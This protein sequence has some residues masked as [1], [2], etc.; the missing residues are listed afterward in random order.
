MTGA[1]SRRDGVRGTTAQPDACAVATRTLGQELSEDVRATLCRSARFSQA[2]R[3]VG[4]ASRSYLGGLELGIGKISGAMLQ[5]PYQQ[6]SDGNRGKSFV[7]VRDGFD[8]SI[9]RAVEY[10]ALDP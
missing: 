9:V 10:G 6:G 5:L 1:T 4:T 8:D 7:R 2:R 3:G